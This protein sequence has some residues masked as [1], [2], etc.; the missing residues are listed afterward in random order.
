MDHIYRNVLF[1]PL[2]Y[3]FI[4][5]RS[6]IMQLITLLDDWARI[7]EDGGCIDNIY[8]HFQEALDSVLV[9]LLK[10]LYGYGIMGK[11][12]EWIKMFLMDRRQQVA[13]NTVESDWSPVTSKIPQGSVVGPILFVIFINDIPPQ[14][15]KCIHMFAD[16]IKMYASISN[17]E[18]GKAL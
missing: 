6:C 10:K 16:D 8:L 13:V 18:D 9:W 17:E 11:V 2:Q 5:G 14:I 7:L 1:S 15:Q 4:R 3:V 12:H